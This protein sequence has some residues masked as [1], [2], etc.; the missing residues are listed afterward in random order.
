M[1]LGEL[2]KWLFYVYFVNFGKIS[3]VIFSAERIFENISQ[4]KGGP[5]MKTPLSKELKAMCDRLET[6]AGPLADD[7]ADR[8]ERARK[9]ISEVEA[10][11][12]EAG[13]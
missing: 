2:I 5:T 8:L 6:C 7:L 13:L 1:E 11:L 9:N 3:G 12:R 4:P 10:E